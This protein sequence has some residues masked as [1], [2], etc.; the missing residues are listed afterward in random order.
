MKQTGC[1]LGPCNAFM[2]QVNFNQ[3]Q[4]LAFAGMTMENTT[5]ILTH[6]SKVLGQSEILI[7]RLHAICGNKAFV[8]CTFRVS[9][10]GH[11][12]SLMFK[13][14][15]MAGGGPTPSSSVSTE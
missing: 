13:G 4:E 9:D 12:A 14:E 3:P 7:Y 6:I 11:R 2:A 5:L 10:V 1:L 8:E 15:D